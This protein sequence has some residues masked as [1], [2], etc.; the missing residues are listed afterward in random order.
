MSFEIEFLPIFDWALIQHS[1][2]A[3]YSS[4]FS[5]VQIVEV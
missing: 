1:F 5:F 4:V 3:N 2:H